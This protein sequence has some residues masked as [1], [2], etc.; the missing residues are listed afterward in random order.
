[1]LIEVQQCVVREM[2]FDISGSAMVCGA[3]RGSVVH[4]TQS[5]FIDGRESCV[6]D[7]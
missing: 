5:T 3:R 2:F 1:M 7:H 6:T 4:I